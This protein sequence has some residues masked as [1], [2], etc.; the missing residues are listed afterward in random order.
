MHYNLAQ[1]KTAAC[2]FLS[3]AWCAST[4]HVS[5][6]TWS[7]TDQPSVDICWCGSVR[8]DW[9]DQRIWGKMPN[10]R[11]P[12]LFKDQDGKWA[13]ADVKTASGW[14][15]RFPPSAWE[16]ALITADFMCE[17]TTDWFID[18][19][20]WMPAG[21]VWVT[22]TTVINQLLHADPHGDASHRD[23][24]DGKSRSR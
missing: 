4:V 9:N 10:R 15:H 19:L 16:P 3:N 5:S 6:R 17:H 20:T 14:R 13:K 21:G 7:D 24:R 23:C 11:P 2:N 18:V 12:P 8:S 22:S 1:P